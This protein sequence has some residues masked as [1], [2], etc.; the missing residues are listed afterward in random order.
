MAGRN[1][2]SIDLA[3]GTL[4]AQRPERDHLDDD[5]LANWVE[6]RDTGSLNPAA[7]LA[8]LRRSA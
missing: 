6:Q 7:T 8:D 3:S 5:E 1:L 2:P 4:V